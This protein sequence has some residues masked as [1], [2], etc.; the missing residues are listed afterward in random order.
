MQDILRARQQALLI[1][2]SAGTATAHFLA[3]KFS[4]LNRPSDGF[5][6]NFVTTEAVLDIA[7]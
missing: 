5:R 6:L 3:D 4:L 2:L 7:H 1:R